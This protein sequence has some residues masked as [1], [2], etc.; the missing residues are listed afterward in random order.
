MHSNYE[1]ET[2]FVYLP[3]FDRH[4]ETPGNASAVSYV[5][6]CALQP[7]LADYATGRFSNR[8]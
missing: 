8:C 3:Q 2:F 7:E 4:S 5:E 1:G 6:K